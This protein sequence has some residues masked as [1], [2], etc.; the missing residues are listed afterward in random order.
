VACASARAGSAATNARRTI[1]RSITAISLAREGI[2]PC[3]RSNVRD[4]REASAQRL[5]S[6]RSGPC[7]SRRSGTLPAPD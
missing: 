1:G 7:R 5:F 2:L 6:D 4:D 3:R